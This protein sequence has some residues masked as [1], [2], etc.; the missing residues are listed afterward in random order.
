MQKYTSCREPLIIVPLA[1][2]M[3]LWLTGCTTSS[4]VILP[5]PEPDPDSETELAS[6]TFIR[7][8]QVPEPQNPVI[9]LDLVRE[10]QREFNQ[11][12][13]SQRYIQQYRPRYGYLMLGTAATGL[14]LYLTNSTGIGAGSLSARER[15]LLNTASVAVGTASFLAMQPSAEPRQAGERRYLQQVESQVLRDTVGVSVP[16][17]RS[18]RLTIRRGEHT[19][20]DDRPVPMHDNRIIVQPALEAGLL[21]LEEADSTDWVV[22]I[23]YED[24]L[25]ERVLSVP[26]FMQSYVQVT[27]AEVPVR[28]DPVALSGNTIRHVAAESRFLHLA[29]VNDRW[30][31]VLNQGN[32]AYIEN[33][34][35]V[36]IW[37]AAGVASAGDLVL[38]PGAAV[39]GDLDIER[40]L[41]DNRG[42]NPEAIAIV[43]ANGDYGE[44]LRALPNAARTAELTAHHLNRVMGY[45]SDNIIVLEDVTEQQMRSLLDQADSLFVGTRHISPAE[46]DVFVYYYGHAYLDDENRLQLLPVDYDPSAARRR[47]VAFDELAGVLSSLQARQLVLVMDTDLSVGSVYSQSGTPGIR[48]AGDVLGRLSEPLAASQFPIAVYWA[49]APGQTA[50]PYIRRDGQPA[51][52]YDIFTWY[53]FAALK[54]GASTSGE[55]EQ[56]LQRQVPFTSRRLHDRPQDPGFIGDRRLRL[57]PATP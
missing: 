25:W 48:P 20:V 45:Y 39:F 1:L 5:E 15:A 14:G 46:S 21:Q 7:T 41:P 22:R 44:P 23:G 33:T 8:I 24:L 55:V 38:S 6:V 32:P 16:P 43:I 50:S 26:D 47:S 19:L 12:L 10:R 56:Y 54:Q 17:G 3:V 29:D 13:V 51:R 37:R 34:Q 49:A 31:R 9:V 40:G 18:A 4:W 11:H 57:Y 42:I 28:S 36:K 30:Y 2:L 53:F 52:P 35:A 27:A